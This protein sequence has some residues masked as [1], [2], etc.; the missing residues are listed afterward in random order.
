MRLTRPKQFTWILALILGILG[1]LAY[2]V[3]LGAISGFAFWLVA[4]AWLLL[5]LA[6]LPG[7]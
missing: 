5:V 3:P 7:F 2:L 1:I 6:A 4:I